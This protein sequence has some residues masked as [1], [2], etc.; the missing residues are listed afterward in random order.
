MEDHLMNKKF[1]LWVSG[2]MFIGSSN[3]LAA[4][5]YQDF[6]ELYY[7][8]HSSTLADLSK[9]QSMTCLDV[10]SPGQT[11]GSTSYIHFSETVPN[12]SSPGYP[13]LN[14]LT[15]YT[16]NSQQETCGLEANSNVNSQL[17]FVYAEDNWS[18]AIYPKVNG[19]HLV[20]RSD[21]YDDSG[22]IPPS[23]VFTDCTP[24]VN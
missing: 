10:S 14:C 22:S 7:N 5:L 8:G 20:F 9:L 24:A 3:A 6:S 16:I 4:D 2:L 23:S 13:Y 11:Q 12:P 18:F 15:Y 19:T 17:K 1:S 21:A